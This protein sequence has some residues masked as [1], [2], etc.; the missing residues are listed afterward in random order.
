MHEQPNAVAAHERVLKAEAQAIQDGI[1]QDLVHAR[2][3]G[4]LI[5]ELYARRGILGDQPFPTVIN[6]VIQPSQD[7]EGKED[8][9]GVYGVGKR[10]L[11]D[12]VHPSEFDRPLFASTVY[13][14]SQSISSVGSGQ[15]AH[16]IRMYMPTPHL[17]HPLHTFGLSPTP[18]WNV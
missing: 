17:V 5:L 6:D 11:N 14:T 3:A 18:C 16:R 12:L 8:H 7:H 10:Y 9:S 13:L 4:Y 2:V 1:T 15:A